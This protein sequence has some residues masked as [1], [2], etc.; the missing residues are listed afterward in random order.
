MNTAICKNSTHEAWQYSLTTVNTI[1]YMDVTISP[2]WRKALQAEFDA[3][4]FSQLVTFVHDEYRQHRCYPPGSQIF[5]AF[6]LCPYEEVKV[7]LLGQDPYHGP[8]QAEGLCFSV[9]DGV[10]FPPS[11]RNIFKEISEDIGTPIP[12]SGSLRRWASQGVLLLNSSLTVREHAP[13][14]HAGKGWE[15]FTDAIVKRLSEERE[16][17]VFILWGAYAQQKGHTIDEQRHLVLRS[18]HPSPFSAY[19]GFFGNKH[20]SQCNAYLKAHGLSPIVW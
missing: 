2:S 6:N 7:V 9:A 19:R 1:E 5:N 11:L 12:Q 13:G 10:L 4:Y 18:A 16:H 20:F 3:P 15:Q 17:L 8:G 14:S